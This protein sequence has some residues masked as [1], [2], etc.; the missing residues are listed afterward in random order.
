MC[1][2][3]NEVQFLLLIYKV[4]YIRK[5]SILRIDQC[6]SSDMWLLAVGWVVPDFSKERNALETSGKTELTT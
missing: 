3:L 6:S 5:E 1:L 4:K 2:I